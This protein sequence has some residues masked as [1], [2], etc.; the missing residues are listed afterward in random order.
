MRTVPLLSYSAQTWKKGTPF[1]WYN[2]NLIK[3]VATLRTTL[4]I[5][6]GTHTQN[7]LQSDT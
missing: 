2:L 4:P 5:S 7:V 1:K 3:P 6:R